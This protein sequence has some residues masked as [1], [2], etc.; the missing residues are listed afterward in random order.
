MRGI[1]CVNTGA[2]NDEIGNLVR[3]NGEGVN[4]EWTPYGKVRSVTKDNGEVMSFLYDAAGNRTSKTV[5]T[6]DTTI[7]TFYVRDASG[8]VMAS[9]PFYN[10]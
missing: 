3:D 7:T 6:A 2:Q 8:N 9:T 4:I 1:H 10:S 5:T